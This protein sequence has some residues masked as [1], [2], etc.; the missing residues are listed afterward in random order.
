VKL[1][2]I[3]GASR[4]L[5]AA[6]AD[7]LAEHA[8]YLVSRSGCSAQF[9]YMQQ[10]VGDLSRSEALDDVIQGLVRFATE[11][12]PESITLINNAG[13]VQPVKP[14]RDCSTA[15]LDAAI[16]TNLIAPMA[17]TAGVLNNFRNLPLTVVNISSGAANSPYSGWGAYC[18]GKAGLDLFTRTVGLEESAGQATIISIA[19]G[20]VD[21]DMQAEIR[22][23]SVDKFP[24]LA[25]FQRMKEEGQL[26]SAGLAAKN[27]V[28]FLQSASFENGG[29]Y[30]TRDMA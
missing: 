19:P 8:L 20:V 4:G 9:S 12:K 27:V 14:I 6:L 17:L 15:E 23:S 1:F 24:E 28:A 10:M 16:K 21:T 3:T 5:G 30:D 2:C 7:E 22:S 11:A 18:A 26:L 25:R 29:V 13:T